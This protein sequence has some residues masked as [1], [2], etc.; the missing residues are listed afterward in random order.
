MTEDE[1]ATRG[2]RARQEFSVLEEA[3]N[4]TSNAIMTRLV[5]TSPAKPD[6]ILQLHMA[7][8]N[9]TAVRKAL[10]AIAQDG[11]LADAALEQSGM[12]PAD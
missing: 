2:R 8:Q 12:L 6:T 3:F 9:L 1:R 5:Q 11:L 4:A 10:L 7:A